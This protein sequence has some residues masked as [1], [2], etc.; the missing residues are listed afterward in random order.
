M[1]TLRTL[2]WGDGEV[3]PVASEG[4]FKEL[5]TFF[6]CAQKGAV[7]LGKLSERCSF[8]VFEQGL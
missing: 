1:V 3:G 6:C 8:P 2:R 4:F 7:A 5:M